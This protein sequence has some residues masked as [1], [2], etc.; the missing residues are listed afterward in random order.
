MDPASVSLAHNPY[1]Y[2]LGASL[3]YLTND[4]GLAHVLSETFNKRFAQLFDS[5]RNW[6]E[7]DTSKATATMCH[8]EK[9]RAFANAF[10]PLQCQGTSLTL[11][12]PPFCAPFI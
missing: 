10:V 11:F 4:P 7:E 8:S 12:S 9:K 5:S 3:T 6:R 2:E 1:I